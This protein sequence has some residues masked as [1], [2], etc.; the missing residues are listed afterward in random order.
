MDPGRRVFEE[1]R[2]P[3]IDE[4]VLRSAGP[5]L[6]DLERMSAD[7]GAAA[8]FAD[9]QGT[10]AVFRGEVTVRRWAE[11]TYPLFGAAMSEGEVGTNGDGTA[12]E[13]GRSAIVWGPEHFA[14][15]LQDS[16]CATAPVRDPIRRSVRGLISLA[17]PLSSLLE[18]DPRFVA[19]ITE[20]AAAEMSRRLT[21]DL[22]IRERALLSAYLAEVGKPDEEFVVVMDDQ[23]TIANQ[24]AMRLLEQ[25]DYAVLAGYAREAERLR[26]P[27]DHE[28]AVGPDVIIDASTR[29]IVEAGDVL[30]SVILL[31]PRKIIATAHRGVRV[32][33]RTDDFRSLVG[34]S[35]ALDRALNVATTV[36]RRRLPACITGETGTGKTMLAT[37]LAGRF[38]ARSLV[39]DGSGPELS[40]DG[41]DGVE[42]I[43]AALREDVAVVVIHVDRAA[44]PSRQR[45]VD[46]FETLDAPP[47]LL[48]SRPPDEDTLPLL[49]ALGG[50][51]IAM[52]ALRD[53]SEDIPPLVSHFLASGRHGVRSVSPAFLRALIENDW[54]GNV[55][56]LKAFVDTAATRC[57]YEQLGLEHLSEVQQRLL[58]RVT[59]SRLEQVELQQIREALAE[60]DGSRVRAAELLQISRATLY[61]KIAA[62]TR[63]G[64]GLEL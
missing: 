6:D 60:A 40:D 63:A 2:E 58:A 29:P 61:R 14:D 37:E 57:P 9:P 20:A 7:T 49:Q 47:V 11:R 31:R 54:V 19:R 18:V 22:A 48:T 30:G 15:G 27:V 8:M 45:L 50:V 64:F 26:R 39:L 16:C 3:Q 17:L 1:I 12:L 42:S 51:E 4:Q 53:R 62:Y 23:T 38:A 36:V 5:V 32:R 25:D 34:K 52:P 43:E 59:L 56:Q 13:E 28:L 10:L 33:G 46:L 21:E 44:P 24:G 41:G 35:P 55:K